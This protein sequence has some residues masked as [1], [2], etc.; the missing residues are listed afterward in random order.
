MA[1]FR[2]TGGLFAS[3]I[4]TAAMGVLTILLL[5]W[6]ENGWLYF[7][8]DDPRIDEQFYDLSIASIVVLLLGP[9][10]TPILRWRRWERWWSYPLLFMVVMAALA[11]CGG[12]GIGTL[13]TV[14][15]AG[16]GGGV[17]WF[18]AR[19][20]RVLAIK[21]RWVTVLGNLVIFLMIAALAG[22]IW[23]TMRKPQQDYAT[24][25]TA[26]VLGVA[27][28]HD[29]WLVREE[30]LLRY[31]RATWRVRDMGQS[32][33]TILTTDH[34][35][36]WA[37]STHVHFSTAYANVSVGST[38][39]TLELIAYQGDMKEKVLT[40]SYQN[41]GW[42]VGLVIRQGRPL[43]V[44]Q[45]AIL[46]LQADGHWLTT[47]LSGNVN[48]AQMGGGNVASPR[49][50]PRHLYIGNNGG[51][52]FGGV[53]RIDLQT[54]VVEPIE[55]RDGSDLCAGPLNRACHPVMDMAQ[56][57]GRA[58]CVLATTTTAMSSLDGAI[59]RVCGHRVEVA[60][61]NPIM[62][63]VQL[64][65]R[66]EETVAHWAGAGRSPYS[67]RFAE[68]VYAMAQT[69]DGVVWAVGENGLYRADPKGIVRMHPPRVERHAGMWIGQV[70]GLILI[71]RWNGDHHRLGGIRTLLV[72]VQP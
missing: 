51:E 48:L 28:A 16:T 66:I 60:A 2:I 38:P 55:R 69:P 22:L 58:D 20:S 4:A 25:N 44:T 3:A 63:M 1:F 65:M 34:D 50:D 6:W 10:S 72:P 35:R 32:D 57:P 54:G 59:L 61:Q 24:W 64:V 18:F 15:A 29:L 41:G 37:L 14:L 36:V 67:Q 13:Q 11:E 68:P 39:G 21:R 49:N 62:P 46:R 53:N 52:F 9:L 33:V 19:R 27:D 7:T 45:T 26:P 47:P 43:I 8:L 40:Q 71:D 23:N 12:G 42:P 30:K 56:D 5:L 17:W 31:D 70:P